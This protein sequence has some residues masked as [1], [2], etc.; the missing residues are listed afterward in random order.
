MTP[1]PDTGD[2]PCTDCGG[3]GVNYQTERRCSCVPSPDAG[4]LV[5]RLT[6]Y[7]QHFIAQ[8]PAYLIKLC[9]EAASRISALEGEVGRRSKGSAN[10]SPSAALHGANTGTEPSA[11]D[12]PMIERIA[13][14]AMVWAKDPAHNIGA[15]QPSLVFARR[16]AFLLQQAIRHD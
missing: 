9:D 5:E 11:L 4:D 12:E 10:A 3:T 2:A 13:Y 8:G 15:D 16:F 7:R 1:S 14:E 6:N